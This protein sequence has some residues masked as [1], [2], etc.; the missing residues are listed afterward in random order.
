MM[1]RIPTEL[2][3]QLEKDAAF[4]R[5][6]PSTHARHILIDWLMNVPLDAANRSRVRE[7]IAENRAKTGGNAK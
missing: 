1:I 2:R 5:V 3:V 7:L 6:R 4:H